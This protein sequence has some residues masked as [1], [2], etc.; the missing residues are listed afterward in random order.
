MAVLLLLTLLNLRRR[1]RQGTRSRSPAREALDTVQA[2]PPE[3]ARVMSIAE[4]QGYDLLRRALPGFLVL[5]Q[6][7]LAR[8]LRVPTRH[9]YTDWMQR[10]G[11]LNAD[12]LLCDGGSRVLAV[13]DIRAPH[14]TE[15]S[16]RRHE[17]LARVLK[18][19]GIRVH[20]WRED[21]LPSLA[22]VR[23]A[24]G[25]DLLPA[26]EP[27]KPTPSR[28]MPLIPVPEIEE[29]LAA[30]DHLAY[31]AALEPVPSAFFDDLESERGQLARS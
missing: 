26:A 23:S 20:V 21:D 19:A 14:E 18:A 25:A 5:A 17:R 11:S 4:R 6:V 3:S 2:W 16:R 1:Q 29:M 15:R 13:I 24:L 31:D 22:A 7:P 8:F 30:G 9:S 12:L 10:V 27:A 28:P